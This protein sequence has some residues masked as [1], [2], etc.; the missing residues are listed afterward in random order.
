LTETL[1][2]PG[3]VVVLDLAKRRREG[4]SDREIRRGL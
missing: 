3:I 1:V 4:K 2:R